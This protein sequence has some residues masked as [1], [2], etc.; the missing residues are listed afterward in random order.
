[1]DKAGKKSERPGKG[2]M[3]GLRVAFVLAVFLGSGLIAPGARADGSPSERLVRADRNVSVA[4][5]DPNVFWRRAELRRESG[6]FEGALEDIDAAHRLAPD[7]PV[8]PIL[9]ARVFL[10]AGQALA[11]LEALAPLVAAEG[12]PAE[13][14]RLR[15]E[16]LLRLDRPGEAAEAFSLAIESHPSPTPSLYLARARAQTAAGG[17]RSQEALAG[18]DEA[19]A[20][21]GPIVSLAREAI[22]IEVESGNFERALERLSAASADARRKETWL[23]WRGRVLE[24]A[25]RVEEARA[26]YEQARRELALASAISRSS[27]AMRALDARLGQS[28]AN[29]PRTEK[30]EVD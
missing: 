25:G 7:S 13:A 4:P 22:E 23:E 19:M 11:A 12:S 6:N 26:A 24:R 20:R 3:L 28:L 29:M 15:A 18:L 9:R 14:Q 30:S 17:E 21:L 16:S 2:G 5:S 8:T 27:S 1:V 10:D